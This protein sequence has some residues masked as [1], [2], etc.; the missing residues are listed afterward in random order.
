MFCLLPA[1]AESP[2]V[3]VI[4]A[5]DMGS[6]DIQ[7]LNPESKIPTPALDSMSSEGI[8]FT[9]GHSNSAVCTPTRYGFI[10]GRYC[11][12]SRLKKGVLNG[13]S[14]HLID[15]D[16]FT[17]ADVFKQKGYKT[18]CIGKWHLGM[19]LPLENNKLVL[20]GKV[21]N[22]PIVNG[23]D[24]FYGIT[25]SLDFPPYVYIENDKITAKEI[26]MKPSRSFPAYLR[27]GETGKNFSHEKSLD[28]LTE[29]VGKYIKERAQAKEKFFLYFPLTSPHKPTLPEERFRGKSGIGPYGDF[30]IQTDW[31]VGQVLKFLKDNKIDDNTMLV[32]TSD[33][34]SYMYRLDSPECPTKLTSKKSKPEDGTDHK[35]DHTIQGYSSAIHRAN[36]KLRGTKAD[37]YEGGH[38]VPFLVR[39]PAK[40]KAGIKSSETI[41]IVDILATC[42]EIV[43]QEIPKGMAEDSFSFL[44]LMEG[45]KTYV[46]PPVITHSANGTFAIHSNGWKFIAGK[47]SG[48]RTMPRSRAFE[49]PYQLYN[50]KDDLGE[51][52]NLI[53]SNPEKAQ[54]LEKQLNAIIESS[55]AYTK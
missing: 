54:D 35:T 33:N 32:Y 23:F 4:L 48:G 52:K 2:N 43:G 55:S 1:F 40:V 3:I 34:G 19:D 16:R 25:A 24:Y 12:R 13:Y 42:S 10:T 28:H 9:D 49:K 11:W 41:S 27:A 31:V 22:S 45:K 20:S 47:G 39:W 29:K 8:T 21:E 51:R 6:G 37:I 38:R 44:S 53:E 18:A 5:D 26:V 17:I 36:G 50:L 46:R 7:A 30:I 15:P 14:K